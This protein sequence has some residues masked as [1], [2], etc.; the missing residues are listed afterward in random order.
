M[1]T[2][3]F[4]RV[5]IE[6]ITTED[7][8]SRQGYIKALQGLQDP[9]NMDTQ[10]VRGAVIDRSDLLEGLAASSVKV[11]LDQSRIWGTFGSGAKSNNGLHRACVVMGMDEPEGDREDSAETGAP[12]YD[13][14]FD[15]GYDR[16]V[17]PY[18]VR[19]EDW[20]RLNPGLPKPDR[21]ELPKA[22]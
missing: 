14:R 3:S 18:P 10:L 20:D 4:K 8:T 1:S 2:D 17:V 19:D 6:L 11:T 5:L 16:R 12:G 13:A 7:C 22:A 21:S 9:I 15:G